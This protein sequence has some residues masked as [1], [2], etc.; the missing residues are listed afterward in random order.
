[1]EAGVVSSLGGSHGRVRVV[2]LCVDLRRRDVRDDQADLLDPVPVSSCLFDDIVQD[3]AAGAYAV[4]KSL[5]QHRRCVFI[6]MVHIFVLEPVSGLAGT[7]ADEALNGFIAVHHGVEGAVGSDPKV[8][9]LISLDIL[10][11]D[12]E[13]VR[14]REVFH[15]ACTA[16]QPVRLRNGFFSNLFGRD[17][18]CLRP[19]FRFR[20]CL[21]RLFRIK[22]R[23]KPCSIS[24]SCLLR[25]LSSILRGRYL[26]LF[27][28]SVVCRRSCGQTILSR[29]PPRLCFRGPF[30]VKRCT[31]RRRFARFRNRC[32]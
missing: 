25:F 29:F 5:G 14:S 9:V 28:A 21:C 20:F 4:I 31:F 3:T 17:S 2:K 11:C 19:G 30:R 12:H 16:C 8:I 13:T 27:F 6:Y 10:F 24:R 1:M 32:G 23:A 26:P 7:E 15:A 18:R 22:S